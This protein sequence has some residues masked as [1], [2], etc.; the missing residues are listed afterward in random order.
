M[1]AGGGR[2][3]SAVSDGGRHLRVRRRAVDGPGVR[4]RRWRAHP[5]GR[6]GRRLAVTGLAGE[7]APG[8]GRRGRRRAADAP[9][10]GALHG[11]RCGRHAPGAVGS[12]ASQGRRNRGRPATARRRASAGACGHR[13]QAQRAGRQGSR[14]HC[15][16]RH[17]AASRPQPRRYKIRT[18]VV[19]R[20]DVATSKRP[21]SPGVT[22]I[23]P[24]GR[25]SPGARFAKWLFRPIARAVCDSVA[26]GASPGPP[27]GA[28][29]GG[30]ACRYPGARSFA[31][32]PGRLL[33]F[34]GSGR[35]GFWS[36]RTTPSRSDPHIRTL[37]SPHPG[38]TQIRSR[39]SG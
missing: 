1:R 21:R 7:A 28:A 8:Q 12:G 4:W 16:G 17:P 30:P 20:E 37:R 2:A 23:V 29:A 38:I 25:P 18:A 31:L 35:S 6:P 9:R 24:T 15:P 33:P 26:R 13:C 5:A 3:W 27:A 10:I 39:L 19:G 36:A 22:A 14:D 34:A 32:L 11:R